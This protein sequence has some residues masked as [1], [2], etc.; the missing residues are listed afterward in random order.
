MGSE[1]DGGCG[2]VNR[3]QRIARSLRKE[4]E[5]RTRVKEESGEERMEG[6]FR[7][8]EETRD[9]VLRQQMKSYEWNVVKAGE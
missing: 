3:S 9:G 1:A 8:S 5:L 4:G 6:D 7:G 2:H